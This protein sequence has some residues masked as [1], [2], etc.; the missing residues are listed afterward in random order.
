[1]SPEGRRQEALPDQEGA[2]RPVAALRALRRAEAPRVA[3]WDREPAVPPA[4]GQQE[5]PLG[6]KAGR[7]PA[8]ARRELLRA[9]AP[10]V[11]RLDR[12][13]GMAPAAAP[14]QP[15]ARERPAVAPQRAPPCTGHTE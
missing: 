7:Q 11:A 8:V 3:R 5:A 4:S 2:L 9:Q 14:A 13:P 15:V 12:E 10:R 1:M 6:L